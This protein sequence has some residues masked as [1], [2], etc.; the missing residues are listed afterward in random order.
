MRE[1]DPVEA[2]I[3]REVGKRAA[4]GAGFQAVSIDGVDPL[5]VSDAVK[6]LYLDGFLE[7]AQVEGRL[8][9]ASGT[10]WEP[11]NLTDKGRQWF[12]SY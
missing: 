10:T 4:G 11:S 5:A 9:D 7:A 3:V 12:E 2:A 8:G 6:R 1:L